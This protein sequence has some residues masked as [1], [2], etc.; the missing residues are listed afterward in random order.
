MVEREKVRRL[1][2]KVFSPKCS[3]RGCEFFQLECSTHSTEQQTQRATQPTV[4]SKDTAVKVLTINVF[5][6]KDQL[7][8][9]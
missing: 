9:T 8:L 1:C 3:I 4:E 6:L 7:N 2:R 5:S